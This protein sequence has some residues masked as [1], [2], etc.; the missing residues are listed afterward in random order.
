[1]LKHDVCYNLKHGVAEH[2][3]VNRVTALRRSGTIMSA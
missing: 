2:W 1:M 3:A